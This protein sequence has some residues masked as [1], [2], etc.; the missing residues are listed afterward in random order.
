MG[1]CLSNTYRQILSDT[2]KKSA[3]DAL[4]TASKRAI[5]ET[6][7]ATSDLMVIKLLIK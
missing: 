6:A 2:A 1:K 3:T 4:K 5:P 7:G